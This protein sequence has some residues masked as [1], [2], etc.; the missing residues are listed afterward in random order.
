MMDGAVQSQKVNNPKK[1][2]H[3][4]QLLEVLKLLPF[5]GALLIAIIPR[6]LPWARSF[7]PFRACGTYLR[8]FNLEAHLKKS[9]LRNVPL[10]VN[11]L[12]RQKY[13]SGL[14]QEDSV[15]YISHNLL[16]FLKSYPYTL[17]QGVWVGLTT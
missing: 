15:L 16:L 4:A 17:K 10:I 9:F 5:Q 11:K 13:D 1:L 2:L 12:Q 6:A 14:F 3:V 7:C 8:K